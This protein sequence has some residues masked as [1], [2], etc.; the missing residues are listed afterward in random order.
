METPTAH[1]VRALVV[2]CL[3]AL[4]WG[5]SFGLEGPVSS[6][7]LKDAGCSD[8]V[9]G[10]CASMHYLGIALA[11]W[12]VPWAMGW[13][14]RGCLVGGM[15]CSGLSVA[16]FPWGM[17]VFGWYVLRL[18]SGV[19][20][21]FC[22]VPIEALVNQN[23]A[24]QKRARDFGFYAFSIA[25]G[26]GIGSLAGMQMYS[27]A[28]VGSFLL[29][30]GVGLLGGVVIWL[31]LP[32]MTVVPEK[33]CGK[34]PL[35]VRRNFLSFGSSWSQGFLEG[36]MMG[37]VPIYLLAIGLT[38]GDAGW[39]VGGT[40]VGVIIIQI[41]IASLA[42]R[43]GRTRVL[44]CCQAGVV[45]ALAMLPFCTKVAGLGS[46]L[47]VCGACSTAFYPLG[48]ALLGERLPAPALPRA[49][50]WYLAINCAGSMM[51]PALAGWAMDV[52]GKEAFFYTGE[53]AVLLV[54]VVWA[55]LSLPGWFQRRECLPQQT[56]VPAAAKR[57]A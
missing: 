13:R 33:R 48:L 44:L 8:T 5:F 55:A 46:W 27:G 9:I 12:L 24:P 37:L 7:W 19:T 26:V 23:A 15:I 17:N 22:L 18:L 32:P 36:G 28:P 31:C 56:E 2:F 34:T 47:F 21:A 40:M 11:A 29:G 20:G 43:F 35:D 52:L 54:L 30:G 41:P 51:G 39:V 4:C 10:A 45:L 25:L 1:R 42:D 16:L 14:A 53:A 38:E 6:Y 3:A 49:N 50:G 57:A